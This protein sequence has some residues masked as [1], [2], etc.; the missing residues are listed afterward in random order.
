[1]SHILLIDSRRSFLDGRECLIA[2]TNVEAL[3]LLHN[4]EKKINEIWFDDNITGKDGLKPVLDYLTLR[5]KLGQKYPVNIIWVHAP[6]EA[7]WQILSTKLKNAGYN[8]QR[9]T[10]RETLGSY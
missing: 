7:G 10:I 2:R 4:N 8:V 9:N 5:S 1:M 6:N 3:H